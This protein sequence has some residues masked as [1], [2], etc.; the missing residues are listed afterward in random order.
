MIVGASSGIGRAAAYEFAKTGARLVL[1]ARSAETL[2]EVAAECVALGAEAIAVAT[3][4]TSQKQVD[5]L[6]ATTLETFGRIDVWVGT[7]AAFAYGTFEQLPEKQFRDLIEVNLFGQAR[8]V[9]AVLPQLRAQGGGSIILMG[10]VYSRTVTAYMGAY[11]VSKHALLALSESIRQEVE[12]D[13]ID[14]SAILP[15]T[16]DTP[17]YQ[18]AANHLGHRVRPLPPYITAERVARVIV[19]RADRPRP[20]TYVGW[21]QRGSIPVSRIAPRIAGRLSLRLLDRVT[22]RPAR[23]EPTDGTLYKPDPGSNAVSG[24]WKDGR[25]ET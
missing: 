2:D 17:I 12:H 7:A 5:A 3:D 14:V 9:R 10:S 16:V 25:T 24:G 22:V 18:H 19:K 20:W 8:G 4:L 11:I 1:A 13:G 21:L 6:V 15:V 23:A